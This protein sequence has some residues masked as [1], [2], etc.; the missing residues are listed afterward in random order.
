MAVRRRGGA[1]L[2]EFCLGL[3]GADLLLDLGRNGGIVAA[4]DPSDLGAELG[5][6][7]LA[8]P[9]TEVERV[10]A[11]LA[12]DYRST[13]FTRRFDTQRR[14]AW[15]GLIAGEAVSQHPDSPQ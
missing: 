6:L 13:A 4:D 7:D 3:V 8:A 5:Q 10:V 1:D 11:G 2:C 15:L 9:V 12:L 14:P